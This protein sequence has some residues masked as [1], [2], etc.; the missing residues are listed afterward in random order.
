MATRRIVWSRRSGVLALALAALLALLV[1]LGGEGAGAAS[2][3]TRFASPL[4]LD[5]SPGTEALPFRTTQRLVG[6]LS[7]GEAGCLFAGT[8]GGGATFRK[9][10]APGSPITLQSYPGQ[11]AVVIGRVS[12]APGADFVTIA[13]LDLVGMNALN[14]SSPLIEGNDVT[15]R[16]NDITNVQTADCVFVGSWDHRV[17]RVLITRNRIHNCGR[18]PSVDRDHGVS[19]WNAIDTQVTS[20]VV[21]D[22]ADRGVQLFP[23]A[24]RTEVSFNVID[25]NGE[26]VLISG[27]EGLTSNDNVVEHNLITNSAIREN[28][29]AFWAQGEPIGTNNVVRA[30]CISGGARDDGDGGV[31][32]GRDGLVVTDNL[33]ADPEYVDALGKDFRLRADS[34][35]RVVFGGTP[36]VKCDKVASTSGSDAAAGTLSQPYRTAQRLLD[37]L[38]AGETGCLR[39][40]HYTENVKAH[41][42][43][44]DG[45]PITLT[46]YQGERATIAGQLYVPD[47]ISFVSIQSLDLDGAAAPI[48]GRFAPNERVPSPLINGDDV[49]LLDND[50]TNQNTAICV[51]VGN[52]AFGTAQRVKIARN[53]IH[54]CGILPPTNHDQAVYLESPCCVK[55]IDN[56]IYDNADRGVQLYPN[57]DA[58]YIARNVIDGNG[59]GV[60][61]SGSSE[62]GGICESSDDNMVENNIITNSTLRYNVESWWDC[63]KVGSGNLVRENCIWPKS[64]DGIGY[65][66]GANVYADP[67]FL[68]RAG[69]DFRVRDTSP[70]LPIFNNPLVIPGSG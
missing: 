24:Q 22:N 67:L 69:K 54:N 30:N 60:I 65:T 53:R 15:L 47:G 64:I 23:N 1:S 10:G 39:E 46:S 63:E 40:G 48:L 5:T 12:V 33:I 62:D 27:T 49:S 16:N 37:S 29:E 36:V 55:V 34:P 18:L 11:R 35:C 2:S 38:S 17:D 4:G 14:L 45:S 66:L 58:N 50:I 57:A 8:Y 26:G 44:A 7:A 41:R 68:D 32:A 13:D 9:A 56:W 70:C 42:S 52:P 3:C 28:V 6:S 20:N 19:V 31:A 61:F 25:G 21:Y 59:E 51:M 43:G